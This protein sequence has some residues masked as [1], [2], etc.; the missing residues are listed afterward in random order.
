MNVYKENEN[1]AI[2]EG[3]IEKKVNY[4]NPVNK[5]KTKIY[6][7]KAI[8]CDGKQFAGRKFKTALRTLYEKY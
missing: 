5:N 6:T 7:Q 4:L 3:C 2:Y 8:Q 1:F